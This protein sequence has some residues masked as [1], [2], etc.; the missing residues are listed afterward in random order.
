MTKWSIWKKRELSGLYGL[1]LRLSGKSLIGRVRNFAAWISYLL[2]IRYELRY[3][4]LIYSRYNHK[5]YFS[6]FIWWVALCFH[7]QK[8]RIHAFMS[9]K[10]FEL[11]QDALKEGCIYT[12]AN[13]HV[14]T[15]GL[16]DNNRSV[17]FA[18]HAYLFCEPYLSTAGDR[19]FH[20]DS[21]LWFWY[22]QFV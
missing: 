19:K 14:R 5:L 11:F 9:A 2:M 1:E 10:F 17:R 22:I 21:P 16:E 4:L 6:Q 15:Y 13:F 8:F 18:K 7:M 12:L 3:L 20:Q